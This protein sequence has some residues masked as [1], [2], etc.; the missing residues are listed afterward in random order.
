MAQEV[1]TP[2][3]L[4]E[5]TEIIDNYNYHNEELIT[6]KSL[7]TKLWSD[8]NKLRQAPNKADLLADWKY[9]KELE[10]AEYSHQTN[11][12]HYIN[13]ENSE[14]RFLVDFWLCIYH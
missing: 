12:N 13:L 1:M 10:S 11:V 14:Q 7:H 3:D 8:L 5:L 4:V 6:P 9:K 2:Q